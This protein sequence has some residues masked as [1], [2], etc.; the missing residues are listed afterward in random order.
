MREKILKVIKHWGVRKQLKHFNSEVFEL[1][2]AIFD[3]ENVKNYKGNTIEKQAKEHIVEEI[4][5]CLLM[6]K[7]F[8]EFYEI[9]EKEIM[10]VI[11]FKLDRTLKK[12]GEEKNGNTRTN[13]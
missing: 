13:S 11:N 12:V 2:E 8:I 6:L 3:Y 5:D 10:Q 1:N 4:A 7:E 9:E